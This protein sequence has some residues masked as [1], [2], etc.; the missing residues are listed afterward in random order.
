MPEKMINKPT[1]RQVQDW[2]RLYKAQ[3]KYQTIKPFLVNVMGLNPRTWDKSGHFRDK[4]KGVRA[5]QQENMERDRE[6]LKVIKKKQTE[7]IISHTIAE[8]EVK[9]EFNVK[10][11]MQSYLL[12]LSTINDTLKDLNLDYKN[13]LIN[14]KDILYYSKSLGNLNDI[15]IKGV[16]VLKTLT[17]EEDGSLRV[18]DGKIEGNNALSSNPFNSDPTIKTVTLSVVNSNID[19]EIKDI[20]TI[21]SDVVNEEV[22]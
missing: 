19:E 8:A 20:N 22:S 12:T 10:N 6:L 15:V 3:S 5:A 17:F 13:K 16:E 21:S 2:I 14:Y 1:S 4:F 7:K 9:L 18:S 11:L